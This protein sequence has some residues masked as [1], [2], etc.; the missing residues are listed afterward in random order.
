VEGAVTVVAYER[1]RV[2]AWDVAFG[3]FRLVQRADFAPHNDG[4]ATRLRLA[5]ET[6]ASGPMRLLVPL[7]RV[8]FRRTMTNSL[9]AIRAAVEA[10][11]PARGS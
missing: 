6:H 1:D 10:T 3:P 7:L 2:A 9:E 4:T 5:I 8:R 11:S